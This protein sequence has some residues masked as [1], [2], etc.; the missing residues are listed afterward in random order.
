MA[1][2]GP[3]LELGGP[4][5]RVDGSLNVYTSTAARESHNG[6]CAEGLRRAPGRPGAGADHAGRDH[7]MARSEWRLDAS[8]RGRLGGVGARG[9]PPSVSSRVPNGADDPRDFSKARPVRKAAAARARTTNQAMN[10]IVWSITATPLLVR[11]RVGDGVPS[12]TE[13]AVCVGGQLRRV[14]ISGGAP[15]TLCEASQPFGASWVPTTRFFSDNRTAFG[16][17]RARAARPCG[18]SP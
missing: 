18:S 6:D 9:G 16:R 1:C 4:G 10:I 17:W 3:R 13:A 12:T 15:V 14:S 2:Q 5:Q 8:S 11:H 7:G